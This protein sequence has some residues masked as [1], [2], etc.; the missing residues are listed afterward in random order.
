MK[1]DNLI[2]KELEE[3]CIFLQN[4]GYKVDNSVINIF[5]NPKPVI[6]RALFIEDDDVVE[7]FTDGSVINNGKRNAKGGYGVY[8]NDCEKYS[9]NYE[10]EFEQGPA[11]NQKT[12]LLAI[13][14]SINIIR[15]RGYN[16][17]LIYSDSMYSINCIMKW[18]KNWIKN[19]WKTANGQDVKNKYIIKDIMKNIK[20]SGKNISFSHVRSHRKEPSNKRSK[21]HR[22]WLGNFNADLLAK[23]GM[24]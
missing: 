2:K 7:I 11:T 21:E 6:S 13:H 22:L 14:E 10:E 1:R 3:F 16:N 18:S 23:Q 12:E 8:I 24:K 4:E 5:L 15:R 20:D 17:I 19:N 9:F